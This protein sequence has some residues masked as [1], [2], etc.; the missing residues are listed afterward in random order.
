[1]N[2]H[3][4]DGTDAEYIESLGRAGVVPSN[5]LLTLSVQT[6]ALLLVLRSQGS[7]SDFTRTFALA[8]NDSSMARVIF[9]NVV[10]F[11]LIVVVSQSIATIVLALVLV[12]LQAPWIRHDPGLA[13][14]PSLVIIIARGAAWFA[15]L[16]LGYLWWRSSLRFLLDTLWGP[17]TSVLTIDEGLNSAW[18]SMCA[19]CTILILVLYPVTRNAYRKRWWR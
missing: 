14:S 19:G 1:M 13:E 10:S 8:M 16:F 7:F 6:L 5:K 15:G 18:A 3:E 2:E 4:S 9:E 12:R 11:C 17:V